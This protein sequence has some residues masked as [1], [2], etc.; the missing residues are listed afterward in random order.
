MNDLDLLESILTASL[1]LAPSLVGKIDALPKD[2]LAVVLSALSDEILAD[3]VQQGDY[4]IAETAFNLL[5][6]DYRAP[7]KRRARRKLREAADVDDVVQETWLAVCVALRKK[8]FDPSR[9]RFSSYLYGI[10]DRKINDK[11][12]EIFSKLKR[13]IPL[14][15]LSPS[16]E[17]LASDDET[18][19]ATFRREFWSIFRRLPARH[20]SFLWY[21]Y[22][23]QY[24]IQ[25]I[26]EAHDVTVHSVTVEL[27]R[28]ERLFRDLLTKKKEDR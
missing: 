6:A 16:S 24:S 1:P 18:D 11:L 2:R 19:S 9:G 7:T 20:R 17:A 15:E 27:T 26:D 21:R 14:E 23:E 8:K 22:V 10:L 13:E 5:E 12:R 3:L 25:K 28:G 4:S